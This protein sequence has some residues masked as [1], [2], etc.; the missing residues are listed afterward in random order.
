[1]G[2]L[3]KEQ[4]VSPRSGCD[5]ESSSNVRAL[6]LRSSII[7]SCKPP[8]NTEYIDS[9]PYEETTVSTGGRNALLANFFVVCPTFVYR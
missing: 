8:E 6:R 4:L 2:A 1:M 7:T 3:S 9:F 5:P